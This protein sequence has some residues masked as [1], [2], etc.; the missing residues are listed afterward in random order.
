M[1]SWP[2]KASI[3]SC[4]LILVLSSAIAA[5][6]E[7]LASDDEVQEARSSGNSDLYRA[8][9]LQFAARREVLAEDDNWRQA[10]LN[11]AMLAYY[12]LSR[13]EAALDRS[14][15]SDRYIK[16]AVETCKLVRQSCS[17][18]EIKHFAERMD[19]VEIERG[20]QW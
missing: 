6:I 4:L 16:K 19:E 15:E 20:R 8:A 1:Y 2:A 5:D 13:L 18:E 3:L 12:K 7:V 17:P 11:D 9:L 14:D 10:A